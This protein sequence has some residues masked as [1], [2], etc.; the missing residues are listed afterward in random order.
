MGYPQL[1]ELVAAATLRIGIG[2]K[3]GTG[4][5]AAPNRIVT[6]AHVVEALP[7]ASSVELVSLR[8]RVTVTGSQFHVFPQEDLAVLDGPFHSPDFLGVNSDL[9]LNDDLFAY[10][11]TDDY[12]DG[13]S[14]TLRY[15]GPTRSKIPL[16]KLKGG[17]V[18]QG[19]SG[20]ALVNLRTQ[21][22][23]GIL[24]VTRDRRLPLGGRAVPIGTLQRIFL[25][26]NSQLDS[27]HTSAHQRLRP[28]LAGR[29]SIMRDD[30][31]ARHVPGSER[32]RVA[33]LLG[34]PR[35]L[36]PYRGRSAV[37]QLA[38]SPDVLATLGWRDSRHP[39]ATETPGE[40]APR[41][42]V[43]APPGLGKSTFAIAAFASFVERGISQRESPVPFLFDLRHF[44]AQSSDKDFG[45][46]EWLVAQMNQSLGLVDAEWEFEGETVGS[47]ELKPVLLLDGLDELLASKS[48]PEISDLMN[49]YLMQKAR[50]IC[51]RSQYF[52]RFLTREQLP[53]HEIITLLPFRDIEIEQY[54][55]GYYNLESGAEVEALAAQFANWLDA[56][57]S[58]RALCAVPLRLNM[59]LDQIRT[60]NTQTAAPLDGVLPLYHGYVGALLRREAAR[61]GS[62][63]SAEAKLELLEQVAFE[64]Y[65]EGSL[66]SADEP[67]LTVREFDRFLA[68]TD[69]EETRGMRLGVI[70]E[71]LRSHSLLEMDAAS[72]AYLGPGT[73]RFSHKSFQEYLVA[74]HV[75][76]ELLRGP[77]R[78]IPTLRSYLSPEV[79]EFLKGYIQ[80]ADSSTHR[81]IARIGLEAYDSL[82]PRVGSDGS[83]DGRARLIRQALGYYLGNIPLREVKEALRSRL[84]SEP[85]MWI[86]R[87][88]TI[89]LAFGGDTEPLNDYVDMLA[90]ERQAGDICPENDVNNG[91]NLT[92]FGDQPLDVLHPE[93]DQGGRRCGKTVTRLI[94]Q[95]QTGTDR[96]SWR[97]D[98]YSILDLWKNRVQSA[99]DC[100]AIARLHLPTLERMVEQFRG[101]GESAGWPEVAA[102]EGLI[103]AARSDHYQPPVGGKLGGSDR[104]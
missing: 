38:E 57:N 40:W 50:L 76:H 102:L 70:S 72:Y 16:L 18:Q 75:Y 58:F 30:V 84:A 103:S 7:P 95:M 56:S 15:E 66:G 104:P 31:L 6:A 64:F 74:S 85:D 2:E 29:L 20:S 90:H 44:R 68:S 96:G 33:D 12:P 52:D 54:V 93:R 1:E 41:V 88:I 27:L 4:W 59:A 61:A 97:L 10:G 21:S 5:F 83:P 45:S 92:F 78:A 47:G 73:L 69:C 100:L 3:W 46:R 55:R 24:V 81:R 79:A 91:F 99:E 11:F 32:V 60:I 35:M 62:I 26:L 49:G 17:Q 71:D 34:G 42:L 39:E 23:A 28:L 51:C 86:R 101:D 87:G 94:Y 48:P 63:L 77:D 89:G 65:D 53:R 43:L 98:L 80:Q 9:R 37:P 13:D 25:E 19:M 82:V 14:L 36:M 8:A 67:L 22:V